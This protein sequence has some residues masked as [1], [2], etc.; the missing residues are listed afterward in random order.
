M[1]LQQYKVMA[2]NSLYSKSR[3]CTNDVAFETVFT[4]NKA[5]TVPKLKK[6]LFCNIFFNT[7]K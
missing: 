6:L 5:G 3:W 2:S 4:F 7:Y 1:I